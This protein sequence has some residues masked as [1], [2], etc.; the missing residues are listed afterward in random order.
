MEDG[1]ALSQP[2]DAPS[3][4]PQMSVDDVFA[5]LDSP[6]ARSLKRRA[7]D[8]SPLRVPGSLPSAA[9]GVLPPS[10]LV[11]YS[12]LLLHSF[13]RTAP[14]SSKAERSSPQAT[15]AAQQALGSRDP[16]V[17]VEE[18]RQV[19]H[20]ELQ[21]GQQWF[22]HPPPIQLQ[23]LHPYPIPPSPPQLHLSQEPSWATHRRH[24]LLGSDTSNS[25]SPAA[26]SSYDNDSGTTSQLEAR[27]LSEQQQWQFVPS[28]RI[29][30]LLH[31][32]DNDS[33]TTSQFEARALSEQQQWQFDP[34]LRIPA[35]LHP[36]IAS[37][38]VRFMSELHIN[39]SLQA[40]ILALTG[41][42]AA[43]AQ[44]GVGFACILC[45]KSF[46]T[47]L[48]LQTHVKT[49]HQRGVGFACILCGKSF[50]TKQHM[51]RHVTTV[52]QRGV[53]V[54]VGFAC[55]LCGKSF[56]TKQHMQTHVKT[57]HLRI[58]EYECAEC[59]RKFGRKTSLV[60]HLKS[61]HSKVRPYHCERCLTTFA[62]KAHLDKH[63]RRINGCDVAP[64]GATLRPPP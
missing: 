19:Y 57:V 23:Q 53:G 32:V 5:K 28:L 48:Y 42:T 10:A 9:H 7:A 11:D 12:R 29:P 13:Y 60:K 37:S 41:L 56:T 61:A 31:P 2:R 44:R 49:V 62:Q 34:S 20:D 45:G 16:A 22:V 50:T 27:A 40:E 18:A 4:Q 30:A 21:Q 46:T 64:P 59:E 47:K 6:R 26:A 35:L 14:P 8:M 25:A 24:P 54:G 43:E 15:K 63:H 51:Q 1:T 38:P 36:A 55:I 39:P 17:A 3:G 33:A 52:H 58:E